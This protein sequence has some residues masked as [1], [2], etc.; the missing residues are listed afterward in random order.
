MKTTLNYGAIKDS[1]TKKSAMEVLKENTNNTLFKFQNLLNENKTLKKQHI[2][3][4]NIEASKPFEKERLAERFLKQNLRLIANTEWDHYDDSIMENNKR[5]RV[6]LFGGINEAQNEGGYVVS[7]PENKLLFESIHTLIEAETNKEFSEFEREAN[8]YEYVIGHLTRTITEGDKSLEEND[9]P[10]FNKFWEFLTQN[11]IS[12]FEQRYSHLNEDEK[13][14]FKILVA[15]GDV[16]INYVKDTR[17]K[18]LELISKK[19]EGSIK[20]D[21]IKL[22]AFREKLKKDVSPATLV[23]DEY[24]FECTQLLTVLKEI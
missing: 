3:Y 5:L 20:E 12:N 6:Q 19:L 9:A 18:A 23:S 10:K 2:I 8:A 21:A 7:S 15:E 1:V 4:K 22:E 16:K 24:I 14:V 17:E 11:A 13:K